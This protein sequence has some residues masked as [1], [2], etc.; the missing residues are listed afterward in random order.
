MSRNRITNSRVR[1]RFPKNWRN[2]V[3][4]NNPIYRKLKLNYI[5]FPASLR[6]MYEMVKTKLTV[7]RGI[8]KLLNTLRLCGLP[9]PETTFK[10][11]CKCNCSLCE[12]SNIVLTI[13]TEKDDMR[14]WWNKWLVIRI[15]WWKM[16][17][18]KFVICKSWQ[19]ADLCD[20]KSDHICKAEK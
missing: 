13:M 9:G 2:T 16:Q 15:C 17:F 19:H 18:S 11:G 4:Q 3:H 10:T 20:M 12:S 1:T 8:L 14:R 6:Y 5:A 7:W